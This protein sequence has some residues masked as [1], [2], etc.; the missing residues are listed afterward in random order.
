LDE[1]PFLAQNS[2]FGIIILG[3][4]MNK[5]GQLQGLAA[6]ILVLSIH[7]MERWPRPALFLALAGMIFWIIGMLIDNLPMAVD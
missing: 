2:Y 1:V 5:K 6:V 7:L 3:G 4:A